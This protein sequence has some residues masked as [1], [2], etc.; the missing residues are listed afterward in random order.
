M[1]IV[2]ASSAK[3]AHHPAGHL[4]T[5]E[6]KNFLK[7]SHENSISSQA[8]FKST[9]KPSGAAALNPAAKK[10]PNLRRKSMA[11]TSSKKSSLVST[12]DTLEQ[13]IKQLQMRTQLDLPLMQ[14]QHTQ[15]LQ[16]RKQSIASINQIEFNDEAVG[17]LLTGQVEPIVAKNNSLQSRLANIGRLD[18][19]QNLVPNRSSTPDDNARPSEKVDFEQFQLKLEK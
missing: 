19:K 10:L 2:P 14:Q 18:S 9:V 5:F 11:S 1:S 4:P 3:P 13:E 7:A 17:G 8:R 15:L 16:D 6:E 12:Y